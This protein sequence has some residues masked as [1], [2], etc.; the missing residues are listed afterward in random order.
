MYE[1]SGWNLSGH[2][3][4]TYNCAIVRCWFLMKLLKKLTKFLLVRIVCVAGFDS[5]KTSADFRKKK[6][7]SKYDFSILYII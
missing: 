6:N 1:F 3:E 7:H 4:A 2:T 5:W